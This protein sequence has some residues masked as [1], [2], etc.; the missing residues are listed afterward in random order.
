MAGILNSKERILDTLLTEEGRRQLAAGNFQ[1]VYYSFSDGLSI[2]QTDTIVSSSISSVPVL[3]ETYRLCFEATSLPQDQVTFEADDSG[4]LFNPKNSPIDV[5]SGQIFSGSILVTSSQFAST[6]GTLLSSSLESFKNLRI[7]SSPNNFQNPNMEFL[8]SNKNIKFNI[9]NNKPIHSEDTQ[10][11]SIDKVESFFMDKRLSHIP[12]F[13]FLPPVNSAQTGR[14]TSSLGDFKNINQES[15][16]SYSDLEKEL[17]YFSKNGFE[18][19]IEFTE[20]TTQNNIFAQFFELSDNSV[21][22]LDV[23]DFGQFT[24]SNQKEFF[25]KHVFFA[26]KI[27]IDNFG[28]TTFINMFTLVFE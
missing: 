6:A 22:K 16:E 14:T 26:G 11:I 8:L 15:F 9:T 23:I 13:S 25:I 12:N 20:T 27:F 4:K 3:D 2:Y 5:M 7:L 10:K 18:E 19:I 28:A 21:V 17:E 24:V 1:A